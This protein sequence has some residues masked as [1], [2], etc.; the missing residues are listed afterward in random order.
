[1]HRTIKCALE[2]LE[3]ENRKK[4]FEAKNVV[5][6]LPPVT[7]FHH[8]PT[9]T[10]SKPGKLHSDYDMQPHFPPKLGRESASYS[11]KNMV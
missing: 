9:P 2:V 8:C 1:M 11:P 4:N 7:L 3:E 5:L 10:T 6:L